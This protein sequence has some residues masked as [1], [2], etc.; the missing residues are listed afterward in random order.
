VKF[1]TDN[2]I[3]QVRKGTLEALAKLDERGLIMGP[4][5]TLD[6]FADRVVQLRANIEEFLKRIKVEERIEFNGFN[7][8]S[9]HAIPGSVFKKAAQK[10]KSLFGFS[11]DWV[12]GYFSNDKMGILFAG[13]AMYSYEDMLA[14]FVVRKAFKDSPKW[15]IYTRDELLSHELTHIAHLGFQ[16]PNYEEYLAFRGSTSNFRRLLGGMFRRVGD[17]YAML[18]AVALLMVYQIF[19]VTQRPPEKIWSMPTPLAF[20]AA[21]LPSAYLLGVW[22]VNHFRFRRAE[23]TIES[24]YPKHNALPVLFRCS[25]QEIGKMSSLSSRDIADWVDAQAEASPRWQ[26]IRSR[27]LS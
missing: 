15:F 4:D 2:L 13:C 26:V 12:P 6:E 5:E 7:L 19:N 16:T 25:E 27:F 24:A 10:T 14:V 20:A 21:F 23:K 17:T 11:V 18:G 9:D 1:L 8:V 3:S 22:C